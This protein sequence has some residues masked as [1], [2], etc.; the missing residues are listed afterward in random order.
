MSLLPPRP[1][2]AAE[3]SAV[4]DLAAIHDL[5]LDEVLGLDRSVL[6]ESLLRVRQFLDSDGS[7]HVSRFNA[8]L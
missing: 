6:A 8:A 1:D 3:M 2:G 5:S 7:E 4:S